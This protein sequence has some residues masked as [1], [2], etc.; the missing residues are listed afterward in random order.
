MIEHTIQE[1]TMATKTEIE[2][3][4]AFWKS[5]PYWDIEETEGFQEHRQELLEYRQQAEQEWDDERQELIRNK[6][7]RLNCS[8]ELAEYLFELEGRLF[9]NGFNIL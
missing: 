3:L 5:D 2:D 8:L 6:A 7:R 4:K 1:K 9:E